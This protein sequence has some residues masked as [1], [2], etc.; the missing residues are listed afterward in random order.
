MGPVLIGVGVYYVDVVLARRF[1]S[2]LPVGSQS[3]FSWA[4]RLCDFPQ[5]IF[6]MALQTATLP[7]LAALVGRGDHDELERTFSYGLRL[8]LFVGLPATGL[9]VALGHPLVVLIFQRGEFDARSALETSRALAAQG[10]GIWMVAAVRQVSAVY[11]ALGDTRTPVVVAALDLCV[12]IGLALW[13]RGP[14]GHVG[15]SI[16]V[17]GASAA[18]MVLLWALLS[19]RLRSLRFAEVLKSGLRTLLCTLVA[20]ALGMLA[21][22][23][24]GAIASPG[25]VGRLL[26]GLTGLLAFG[27]SFLGAAR[28]LGSE[29]LSAVVSV[30][31]RRRS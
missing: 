16:A 1:L 7:T 6:V 22:R 17:T 9:F 30:A 20:V 11:Y 8:A 27:A 24:V 21:A 12:F 4:M 25:P 3:Y 5:G 10:L 13:L 19:R 26:P 29:E 31:R 28:A 2:E 18:Q 15:V 14:L 23:A